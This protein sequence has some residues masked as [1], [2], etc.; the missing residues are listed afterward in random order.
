M[1][2]LKSTHCQPSCEFIS[3]LF[4]TNR[5]PMPFHSS[6]QIKNNTAQVGS[7][8]CWTRV[9][10][11]LINL[12]QCTTSLLLFHIPYVSSHWHTPVERSRGWNNV[13]AQTL[14]TWQ[15]KATITWK[16]VQIPHPKLNL[17]FNNIVKSNRTMLCGCYIPSLWYK[18][19][20][21]I[22]QVSY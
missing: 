22:P 4:T 2:E 16:S 13:E 15:N 17:N 1:A 9:L 3:N 14:K 7:N 5:K 10:I 19:P 8:Q 18:V 20:G 21:E 12:T 6:T 11:R